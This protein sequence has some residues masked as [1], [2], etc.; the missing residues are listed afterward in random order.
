[1]PYPST[2]T[3]LYTLPH[4]SIR[5]HSSWHENEINNLSYLSSSPLWSHMLQYN[6]AYE[7]W[8]LLSS[9][10]AMLALTNLTVP[11]RLIRGFACQTGLFSILQQMALDTCL[12]F[13]AWTEM[14]QDTKCFTVWWFLI[15]PVSLRWQFKG[16][17]GTTQYYYIKVITKVG[18]V[19]R[20]DNEV[21]SSWF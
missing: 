10:S 2:C 4:F 15:Q 7:W 17:E 5:P 19:C 11:R 14:S 9:I 21:W 20:D 16:E 6:A 1:M 8:L 12:F 3:I 18:F 13:C